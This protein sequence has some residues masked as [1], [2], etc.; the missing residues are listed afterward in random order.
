M[1]YRSRSALVGLLVCA[2]LAGL[3]VGGQDLVPISS[4][5]GGSSVFVIRNAARNAKRNLPSIKPSRTKAQRL[6]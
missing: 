1:L 4:L 6:E 5:T 3:P 2:L